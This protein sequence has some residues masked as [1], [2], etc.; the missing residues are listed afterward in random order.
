VQ[1]HGSNVNNL[2]QSVIAR[3][4]FIYESQLN[5]K[6]EIDDLQVYTSESSAPSYLRGCRD[7]YQQLDG[8]TS[9]AES[10]QIPF[11]AARHLLTG[12][13]TGSGVVGLAYVGSICS[14][15]RNTGVNQLH[16]DMSWVI[17][18]HELGHNFGGDHSFE[19][20]QGRTGGIMDYGDGK[21]NGEYQFNTRYRKGEMC[22]VM[23]SVAGR[24][25][26]KFAAGNGGS[27]PSPSPNPS[28]TPSS[29]SCSYGLDACRAAAERLGLRTSGTGN[30]GFSGIYSEKGCYAYSDGA[31]KSYAWYGLRSDGSEVQSEADLTALGS[32]KYRIDGTH[33]CGS[34]NGGGSQCEDLNSNCPTW[35]S[36]G[37]CTGQFEQYM[38]ATC[39]RT[40]NLCNGGTT[41]A[42]EYSE[43]PTWASYDF[44]T[45]G[46]Y[47][48]FMRSYC[49]AS[50]QSCGYVAYS[51]EP[52]Q[53]PHGAPSAPPSDLLSGSASMLL[54]RLIASLLF[55]QYLS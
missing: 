7:I 20:G 49:K 33:N 24:C 2:V 3:T 36:N 15:S 44:C 51:K 1:K 52:I 23:N 8:L 26:G 27:S 10:G 45:T 13:G 28:P 42:D 35:G 11:N 32:G 17:F 16:N 14:A 50:C 12:C 39:K 47:V 18:A 38:S 55:F 30:F 25:Q 19:E 37:Y 34:G 29:G 48:N 6:V 41:C 9:A 31:Y 53:A 43:C 54:G 4:S 22:S 21:L 40:C 46:E 5:I